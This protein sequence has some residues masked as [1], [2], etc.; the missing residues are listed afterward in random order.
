M[1]NRFCFCG[2]ELSGT[3]DVVNKIPVAMQVR[4]QTGRTGNYIIAFKP[5]SVVKPD[6]FCDQSLDVRGVSFRWVVAPGRKVAVLC[7]YELVYD[8]VGVETPR[9][10]PST[11]VLA[12]GSRRPLPDSCTLSEHLLVH[13]P[14]NRIPH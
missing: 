6:A 2:I 4:Q 11:C 12:I 3:V 5:R 8:A 9:T 7:R 14:T 10:V 13:L 1:I